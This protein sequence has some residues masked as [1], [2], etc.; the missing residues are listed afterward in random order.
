MT[1]VLI[2]GR[3]EALQ[4]S[5]FTGTDAATIVVSCMNR[6]SNGTLYGVLTMLVSP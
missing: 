6:S 1:Q 5:T 2:P 4:A 3:I